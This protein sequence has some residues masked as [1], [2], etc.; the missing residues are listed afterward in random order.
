MKT[1]WPV[2]AIYEDAATREQAVQFC[3]QLVG[4][5]WTQ[6]N[7]EVSWWQFGLLAETT[8]ARAASQKAV[9]SRLVLVAARAEGEWS[10][11][12]KGW[13]EGWLYQRSAKEGSLI[14]LIGTG[15]ES[16]SDTFGKHV[17]LRHV[18]RRAGLN[19]LTE[20]PTE[21]QHFLPDSLDSFSERACQMSGVLDRILHQPIPPRGL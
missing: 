18:A 12:V 19:Y 16:A 6:C 8:T 11:I 7:F 1:T 4:R 13:M 3:D 20:L 10:P 14:G 9:E 21:L 5:F 2:V 15:V 17:Y